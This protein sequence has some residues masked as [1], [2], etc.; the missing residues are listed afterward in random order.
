MRLMAA[1]ICTLGLVSL[2]SSESLAAESISKKSKP[3]KV[4]QTTQAPASEAQDKKSSAN[5]F[6]PATS[7]T[8]PTLMTSSTSIGSGMGN[9]AKY[10][11][12]EVLQFTNAHPITSLRKNQSE[13][14]FDLGVGQ[15]TTTTK[16]GNVTDVTSTASLMHIGLGTTVVTASGLRLGAH[17][18]I[19]DDPIKVKSERFISA[20]TK[21]KVSVQDISFFGAAGITPNFGMG[22][23]VIMA[24]RKFGDNKETATILTPAVM[25][26]FDNTEI[27]F[28]LIQSNDDVG[29]N[30]HWRLSAMQR[31]DS[32]TFLTGHLMRV[33]PNTGDDFWDLAIGGRKKKSNLGSFGAEL[34]YTQQRDGDNDKCS[35]PSSLGVRADIDHEISE[36]QVVSAGTSY[37]AGKCSY[38]KVS[39]TQ[40][41]IQFKAAFTSTF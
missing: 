2:T 34:L 14:Q 32:R 12:I 10:M 27:I 36:S 25:G 41:A 6:T 35:S 37:E 13:V 21:V 4:S 28:D 5:K 39:K 20:T 16:D 26:M 3:I 18:E 24:D 9:A 38:D 1:T 22:L 15:L 11:P 8:G 40:N 29:I 30:G 7:A 33:Q 31:L 19:A 17:A 23:N